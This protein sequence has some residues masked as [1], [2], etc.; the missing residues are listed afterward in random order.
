MILQ[1]FF[2]LK[3]LELKIPPSLIVLWWLIQLAS[4]LILHPLIHLKV[5]LGVQTTPI[6]VVQTV[7][8]V[9]ATITISMGEV[10]VVFF[11]RYAT[12]LAT[13]LCNV[14]IAMTQAFKVTLLLP[15]LSWLLHQLVNLIIPSIQTLELL[16]I[17]Q[18]IW[19]ISPPYLSI[20]VRIRFMWEMVILYL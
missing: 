5:S 11:V 17:S 4:H 12:N 7:V 16:I 3:K 15:H 10:A 18:L 6:A 13:R 1:V 14:T 19:L 20:L 8:T 2:Y 9:V